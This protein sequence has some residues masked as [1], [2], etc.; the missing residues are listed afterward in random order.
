MSDK[1][2][3]RKIVVIFATDVV[4]YSKHIEIDESGTIKDL[5]ACEKLI[6]VLLSKHK[7][8]LFNTGAGSFLAEFP[9][10]VPALQ[11]AVDSKCYQ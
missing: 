7:G 11:C 2:I 8:R 5:R 3:E 6:K 1:E 4:G 9:G 10:A